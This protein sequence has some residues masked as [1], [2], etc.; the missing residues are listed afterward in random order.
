MK[1]L[2]T[3][4][5]I[6]SITMAFLLFITTSGLTMDMHFCG[7]QL[8][9]VNVFGKAKTCAEVAIL[10][11][12]CCAK[13]KSCH[14]KSKITSCGTNGDHKGCCNNSAIDLDLDTDLVITS[15]DIFQ[16][17]DL[18]FLIAFSKAYLLLEDNSTKEMKAYLNY[19]P[20]LI[21]RDILV[22]IQTFLC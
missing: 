17:V 11:K 3:T 10:Q 8:K 4:Y 21:E 7:D 12:N 9:R 5:R 2:A 1:K 15:N 13:K 14:S 22:L 6:F 18:Q 20:P 19:K 16:S